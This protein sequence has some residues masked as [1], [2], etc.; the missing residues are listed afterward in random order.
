MNN[1]DEILKLL[2]DTILVAEV[3]DKL[4]SKYEP[5]RATGDSFVV[6]HLHQLRLLLA[7]YQGTL[8]SKPNKNVKVPHYDYLT[9]GFDPDKLP[10]N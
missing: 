3:E 8:I 10:K 1:I 4:L 6:F 5:V 7:K 9:E 2:D